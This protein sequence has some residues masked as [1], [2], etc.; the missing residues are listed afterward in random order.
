ME[1]NPQ[2]NNLQP[3]QPSPQPEQPTPQ[4]EEPKEEMLEFLKRGEARTMQRDLSEL[5]ETEAEQEKQ[6]VAALETPE[7]PKVETSQERGETILPK[8]STGQEQAPPTLIPH[9]Q[10]PPSSFKK[11]VIRIAAIVI[12]LLLIGFF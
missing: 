5:R 1:N 8:E 4:P 10:N 3:E 6:K 7:K 9:M 11:I 2:P 12:I